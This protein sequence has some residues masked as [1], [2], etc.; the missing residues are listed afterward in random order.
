MRV[1]SKKKSQPAPGRNP[2]RVAAVLA[3]RTSGGP[4]PHLQGTRGERT[5]S[6]GRLAAIRDSLD[7][8]R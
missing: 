4:G 8:N 1:M 2:E 7:S 5:R 6:G 3:R